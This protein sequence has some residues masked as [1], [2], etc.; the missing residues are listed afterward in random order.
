M[1]GGDESAYRAIEPLLA[2]IAARAG[3]RACLGYFGADGAGH[4]VKMAHNA[5][6]YAAMAAIAEAWF[7]LRHLAG[8]DHAAA[9]GAMAAWNR[10]AE[11]SYLLEITL[12]VLAAKD[13]HSGAPFIELIQDRA[14]QKGTGA[15]AVE[16]ALSLGVPIPSLAEA[17]FQRSLSSLKEEREAAERSLG[18]PIA[19]PAPDASAILA[20]LPRALAGATIAAHAQGF[21]LM[22]AAAREHGWTIDPA[23]V[24]AVWQGGC[25]LRARLLETIEAAYLSRPGL[26]NLM[27]DP[28]IAALL[29]AATPGWRMSVARAAEAGIAAPV[30]GAALAYADGYRTGRGPAAL[31]QG[32]R[33][34]FGGHGLQLIGRPGVHHGPWSGGR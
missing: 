22:Q 9:Q 6:E 18:S 26:A 30:T 1:A 11:E 5:I 19:R 34:R 23:A 8:L 7:L 20:A 14:E 24:A 17:V 16:A 3:S 15:W 4:F 33:D 32:Q 2:R 10:G 27:L 31:I 29:S 21:A 25:I 13:A 28:S 12:E